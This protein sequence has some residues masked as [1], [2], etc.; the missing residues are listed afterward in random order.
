MGMFLSNN[1]STNGGRPTP[2]SQ[3]FE[4][5]LERRLHEIFDTVTYEPI[6]NDLLSLVDQLKRVDPKQRH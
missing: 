1:R 4:V 5:W 3:A 6:P 2:P